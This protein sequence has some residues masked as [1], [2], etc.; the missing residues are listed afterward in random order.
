MPEEEYKPEHVIGKPYKRGMLPYG[1][2]VGPG[3]LI[4]MAISEE[5]YKEEMR[6]LKAIL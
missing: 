5:Q 3:G 6:Q 1:G 2:G 4:V